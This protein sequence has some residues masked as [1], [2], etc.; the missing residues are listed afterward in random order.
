MVN[1]GPTS[2][3]DEYCLNMRIN[4]GQP[5]SN[6]TS[7]QR[8][9]RFENQSWSSMLNHDP[10]SH[11]DKDRLNMKIN[12]GQPWPNVALGQIL[13]RY[14]SQSWS[15]MVQHCILTRIVSIWKSTMINHVYFRVY[16]IYLRVYI[17]WVYNISLLG[18]L[19]L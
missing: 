1:H 4:H 16:N 3:C 5:R 12:N 18:I 14:E 6:V 7:W 9:S 15:S 17:P 11:Y 19:F 13:P 2:Q 10:T 8:F